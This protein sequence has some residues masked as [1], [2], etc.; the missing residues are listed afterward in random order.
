[1]AHRSHKFFAIGANPEMAGRNNNGGV[2]AA[3]VSLLP[4]DYA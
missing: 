3:G 2:V 4:A 1:M